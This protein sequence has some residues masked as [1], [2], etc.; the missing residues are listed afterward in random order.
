MKVTRLMPGTT[1]SGRLTWLCVSLLLATPLCLGQS[2]P[3]TRLAADS[4][5]KQ[6]AHVRLRGMIREAPSA[7]SIF[8]DPRRKTLT[9]WL[10]RLARIRKDSQIH[11]VALEIDSPALTWS[12]A[13]ELA[14]AVGRLKAVKP[15]YVHLT[16]GGVGHFL[17]GSAGTE[18][19]M[20]PS[21]TLWIFGLGSEMLFFRRTLDRLHMAPQLIQIGRYKGA[22]EPLMQT[23]PSREMLAVYNLM[24]DDLYEQMCS[25]I[26]RRRGLTVG[27]V[28]ATIDGGPLSAATASEAKWVDTLVEKQDW[29]QH[30]CRAVAAGGQAAWKADHARKDAEAPDFSNPFSVLRT[31]MGEPG[32]P[33]RDPTLAIVHAEGMIVDG[34]GGEGVLGQQLVGAR[35]LVRAFDKVAEDDRIKA[36]VFRINSPGG[37]ALAS[38]LIYQAVRRCAEKK[39]VIA[40]VSQMAASGGYYVAAGARKIVANPTA[41]VGSIGVVG[42]KIAVSGTMKWLGVDRH[43]LTRGRNA[44]LL[45]S[46]PWTDREQA[47]IRKLMEGTYDT[48]VRRVTESRRG[49]IA[50]IDAVAQGRIFTARQAVANGLIDA[51]GGLN[52]AVRM[53]L[54]AADVDGVENYLILPRP[55]TL[56]EVLTG[57]EASW[58]SSGARWHAGALERMAGRR[59]GL[60]YLINLAELF[61]AEPVLTALPYHVSIRP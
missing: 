60:V 32:Q 14:N 59:P 29:R 5:G 50:R 56:K 8:A 10:R 12:Q 18:L 25:S 6:I 42:G 58:Q 36:A 3:T 19:A 61:A 43:E 13:E 1:R 9:D 30:V 26:A 57:E 27:A 53:A 17:I 54:R 41:M 46:R 38:E 21:G 28:R 47:V 48:F 35:T 39:P 23:G 24:L 37:S 33:I 22:A 20:E 11:A 52:D 45:M 40:S 7:F 55:R 4:G 51:E 15:V 34:A 2:K 16:G 44:G 49:K 31:L